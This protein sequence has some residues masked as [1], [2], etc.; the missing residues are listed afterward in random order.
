M[1]FHTHHGTSV[2]KT[3]KSTK[4]VFGICCGLV[5]A[6]F[7]FMAIACSFYANSITPAVVI[8]V[9]ML[10]LA[11]L[12]AITQKDMDKASVEVVNDVITVT[13]F[14]FGIKR[15]KVYSVQDI[16][17]AEVLIGYSMRVRGYRYSNGGMT[18]IVFK[19]M[20]GK[21]MFKVLCVP[22]TK[23]LFEAYLKQQQL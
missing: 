10:L 15:E 5:I 22:E 19:D 11:V 16:G 17:C 8:L 13:D 4:T 14:Y 18:Y 23:E 21:Y 7:F 20:N 12:I 3:E 6:I 1:K 9:P 2:I